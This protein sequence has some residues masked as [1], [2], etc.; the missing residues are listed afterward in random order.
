MI[1]AASIAPSYPAYFR[2]HPEQLVTALR[3]LGFQHVEETASV[4]G[5]AVDM[6]I[7][8]SRKRSGPII[9]TS[10]PRIAEEII[11][12]WPGLKDIISEVPSPMELHGN[13]LRERFGKECHI[14]FFSPCPW[15][16]DENNLKNCVDEVVTFEALE[17]SLIEAGIADLSQLTRTPFDSI[18]DDPVHRL[19]PLVMGV[20]GFD[21]CI[22]RLDDPNLLAIGYNELLWCRGGCFGKAL[23]QDNHEIQVERIFTAWEE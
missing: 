10:C 8:E 23:K 15:K 11:S 20:H 3:L 17:E 12:G 5:K 6:R 2:C 7:T 4:V 18:V 21:E 19:S 22:K 1:K 13:L 14:T 9:G 16:V